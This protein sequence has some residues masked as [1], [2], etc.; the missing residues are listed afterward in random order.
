MRIWG[1]SVIPLKGP[2]SHQGPAA[3]MILEAQEQ[4]KGVVSR[5]TWRGGGNAF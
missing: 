2:A 3:E 1:V 5:L 4:I